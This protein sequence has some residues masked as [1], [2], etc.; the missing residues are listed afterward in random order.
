MFGVCPQKVIT[1]SFPGGSTVKNPPA[2]QGPGS[3]R[4]LRIENGN[5]LQDAC[6]GNPMHRGTG[7]AIVHGVAEES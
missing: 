4:C 2:M 5:P 1:L 6:L 7:W 3:G